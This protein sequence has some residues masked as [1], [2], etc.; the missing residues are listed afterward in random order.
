MIAEVASFAQEN[1]KEMGKLVEELRS[2]TSQV[3]TGGGQKAIERHTSRGKLLARDRINLLLDRGSSFLE[4]SALAG[5]ELYGEELV[6]SG[7]IVTGVG[8]VCGYV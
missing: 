4:L 3:L 8:R 2:F 5:H 1:A 7:G 6:N